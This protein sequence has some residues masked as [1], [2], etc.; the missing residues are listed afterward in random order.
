[1]FHK[2]TIISLILFIAGV[3]SAHGSETGWS[4]K[5][6]K[7]ADG[8]TDGSKQEEVAVSFHVLKQAVD[9]ALFELLEEVGNQHV[10]SNELQESK[11]T[12][13]PVT[14]EKKRYLNQVGDIVFQLVQDKFEGRW[15]L[16]YE[17]FR[18][19]KRATIKAWLH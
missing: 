15:L 4:D 19:T 6:K 14:G 1:M 2:N 5:I 10:V 18:V 13:D 16:C 8:I 3:L 9:Q 12:R 7:A 11:V 17:P